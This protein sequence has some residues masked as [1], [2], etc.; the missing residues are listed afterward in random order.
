[1]AKLFLVTHGIVTVSSPRWN[2]NFPVKQVC[3]TYTP[4][5]Y[6][7]WAIAQYVDSS[8]IG[9]FNQERANTF[10]LDAESKLRIPLRDP[11]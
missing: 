10:A 1:M 4:D 9:E 8:E 7:G 11:A 5:N 3:V 2:V 6:N